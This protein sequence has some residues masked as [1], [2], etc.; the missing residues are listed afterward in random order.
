MSTTSSDSAKPT[1]YSSGQT[2]D[3][4]DGL[5]ELALLS[6]ADLKDFTVPPV[7]NDP[8]YI[9]QTKNQKILTVQR[10]WLPYGFMFALDNANGDTRRTTGVF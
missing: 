7:L 4:I 9:P 6:G 5:I 10:L 3:D 2:S 1:V 8:N